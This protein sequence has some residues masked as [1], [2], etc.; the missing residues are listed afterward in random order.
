MVHKLSYFFLAAGADLLNR[1]P[2]HYLQ[3][4]L[5][6]TSQDYSFLCIML[7]IEAFKLAS[8]QVFSELLV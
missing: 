6:G 2:Y 1:K 7:Y 5:R 3:H 4:H 8:F